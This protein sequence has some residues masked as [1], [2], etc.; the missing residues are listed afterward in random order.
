M[1]EGTGVARPG[2]GGTVTRMALTVAIDTTPTLPRERTGIGTLV[3]RLVEQLA[4]RTDVELLPYAVSMRASVPAGTRRFPYPARAALGGWALAGRPNGRH[5]LAGAEVVHGTNYVVPPTGWPTVVS[6]HDV[7]FV[8]RPELANTTV[9]SF[10][11]LIRRATSEGAWVHTISEHVATQVRRLF[12]TDRVRVVYPGVTRE[13]ID[14]EGPAPLAGLDGRPYVLALGTREPR[15]NFTRLVSAFGSVHRDHPD[16]QLVLAGP[17]GPDDPAIAEAI[18]A[19]PR[20]AA[21]RVLVTDWLDEAHRDAVLTHAALLVYPSLDEGFG[22]P[23]LE[24]MA[25]GVPVV[26]ARA[27]AVPEVVGDAAILVDPDDLTSIAAGIIAGLSDDALRARLRQAGRARLQ[28]FSWAA[29]ADGMVTLYGDAL[30]AAG[31]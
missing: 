13:R 18:R 4:A 25:A 3:A 17:E 28:H 30:A 15:K 31:R 10:V 1:R 24:A 23:A 14:A 16:V 19:L 22:F 11:P 7:S 5:T 20:D 26:A 8:T 21:Q 29:M 12:D 9:R 27:G 6:V 2:P